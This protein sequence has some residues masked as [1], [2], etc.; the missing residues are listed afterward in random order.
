M[1]SVNL[2]AAINISQPAQA[3]RPEVRSK[4][5]GV[6]SSTPTTPNAA[7]QVSVSGRAEQVGKMVEKANQVGDIR[8]HRVDALRQL[9]HFGHYQVASSTIAD[10]ILRD[11]GSSGSKGP[12]EK[13]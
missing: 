13:S 6:Q 10:A 7:D 1:K 12:T 5:A 9:I 3:Q 11:E 8:Q 2:D 4:D